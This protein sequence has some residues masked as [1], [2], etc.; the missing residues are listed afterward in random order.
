MQ[1]S[2]PYICNINRTH[3]L[4]V[5]INNRRYPSNKLPVTFEPRGVATN[6][7]HFPMLDAR[8]KSSVKLENRGF[9]D[10]SVTFSP[11]N[12]APFNGYMR[13]ID[14]ESKLKNIIFPDQKAVQSKFIPSSTSDLYS[15]KYLAVGRNEVNPF[16]GLFRNERFKMVKP[17]NTDQIGFERFYNHTRQQTKNLK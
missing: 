6:R 7:V 4:D 16:P 15:N 10:Q 8:K 5:R 2:E 12:S 14:D 9:F 13:N 11:G 17:C 1:F 3:D